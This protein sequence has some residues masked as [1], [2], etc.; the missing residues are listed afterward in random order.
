MNASGQYLTFQDLR[1]LFDHEDLLA[2]AGEGGY[3]AAGGRVLNE[4]RINRVIARAQSRIDGY[5]LSRFP[6]LTE[7]EPDEMPEALKGAAGDMVFYWLRD[8]EGDRGTVDN[9]I[10]NRFDDAIRYLEKIQ[11]GKIDLPGFVQTVAT[12]ATSGGIMG[13]FPEPRADRVLDGYN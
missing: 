4:T 10:K 11:A 1:D 7:T 12:T 3:N 6:T 5:V 9:V 8:R 2:I 13:S